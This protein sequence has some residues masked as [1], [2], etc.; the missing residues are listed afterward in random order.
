MTSTYEVRRAEVGFL[1]SDPDRDAGLGRQFTLAHV[2][3]LPVDRAQFWR[4]DVA[5]PEASREHV[6]VMSHHPFL[7]S[8]VCEDIAK[9]IRPAFP[10]AILSFTRSDAEGHAELLSDAFQAEAE[11]AISEIKRAGGW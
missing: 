7:P 11:A 10:S 2:P 4:M 5:S 1:T 6:V 3:G 9:L 8:S